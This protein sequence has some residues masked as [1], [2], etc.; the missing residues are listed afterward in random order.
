MPAISQYHNTDASKRVV[1]KFK[2][3]NSQNQYEFYTVES[4][5]TLNAQQTVYGISP[6]RQQNG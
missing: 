1:N 6:P 3:P 4:L 2:N 5:E